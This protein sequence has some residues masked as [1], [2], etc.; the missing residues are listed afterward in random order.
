MFILYRPPPPSPYSQPYTTFIDQL[1]CSYSYVKYP[2]EFIL[3][4]DFNIHLDGPADQQSILAMSLLASFNLTQ[5]V[6]IPTRTNGHTLDLVITSSNSSLHS[7][8]SHAVNTTSDHFQIFSRCHITPNPPTPSTTFTFRGKN[9]IAISDFTSDLNASKL[10]TD[11]QSTL[12]ELF[13]IISPH[14]DLSFINIRLLSPNHLHALVPNL[15]MTPDLLHFEKTSHHL[16]RVYRSTHSPLDFKVLRTA[17]NKY[18]KLIS[19]AKRTY[20]SNLILSSFSNPRLLWSTINFLLP[21]ILYG[22]FL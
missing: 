1:I 11:P 2:H 6:F 16:E 13:P 7:V 10:I 4:G 22:P 8:I 18:H 5:H 14:F 9:S 3:T 17:T 19:L 12:L 20:N 21:A 15:W